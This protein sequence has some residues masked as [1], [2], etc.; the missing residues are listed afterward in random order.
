MDE[1]TQFKRLLNAAIALP[2]LLMGALALLLCW[3]IVLLL[4]AAGW[5]DHTD[6]VIAQA[7]LT[8]RLMIDQETGQRG[9]LV[10]GNPLF[11]QPY[12]E[13][14]RRLN[15]A[16]D[17]LETLIKD[18][19]SQLALLHTIRSGYRA[20]E[21]EARSEMQLLTSGRPYRDDF[22]RA[23]GKEL[24][25]A[26]RVRYQRFL[27][28]EAAM[29]RSRSVAA[30]GQ[31]RIA[32]LI[33]VSSSLLLGLI[34]V[35]LT[36]ERLK[37]LAKT[38]R[39]ALAEERMARDE[40]EAARVEIAAKSAEVER[41]NTDLERRVAERTAELEATNHELEAFS[42]SVSHDLRAPLRSI[43]GFS[44]ALLEDYGE[45][46][47]GL[48]KTYLQ[49]IRANS[50]NMA[51]LIDGLLNLSRL[52]RSEMR[53]ESVNL[54]AIAQEIAREL[55]AA[56]PDRH[57]E[58]VIQEDLTVVGDSTLLR[59]VMQ[60]LLGNAWKFTAGRSPA[61]IEFGR[62]Q[63]GERAVYFVRDNGAGF[64][65]AYVE[66]LFGAFQRLH[67]AKEFEGTGIGLATVQRVIHRHGGRVWA[68][69]AVD[70]GA[71]FYFTLPE[72]PATV[73]S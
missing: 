21:A 22:N 58:F 23:R 25:D 17:H 46:V 53:S 60:N 43:D 65:M 27:D 11:L 56:Q 54:S 4:N 48:G 29:R 72:R 41:L 26:E 63:Q 10:S 2:M 8:L 51:G 67:G 32:L 49:R 1:A 7:N 3:Q 5:V 33:T 6:A 31:G 57:A 61:R 12:T 44:V 68:E 45:A 40:S 69:G 13:A 71:T 16:L 35:F 28:V 14:Q 19:P 66:K 36:R 55:Q 34:I 18:N 20:W 37:E 47:D 39:A 59:N 15:P 64:D 30:H 73:P 62:M 38:Y 70:Q 42:Y 9:Y 50:Q 52:T 24:M